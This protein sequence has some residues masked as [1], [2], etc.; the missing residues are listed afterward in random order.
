[1]SGVDEA[2]RIG[3]VAHVAPSPKPDDRLA[4]D[5]VSPWIFHELGLPHRLALLVALV[6]AGISAV[7]ATIVLTGGVVEAPTTYAAVIVANVLG[8]TLAGLMWLRSRPT[9]PYG[10]LLLALAVGSA[11]VSLIGMASPWAH[12]VGVGLG[13]LLAIGITGTA[14]TFPNG[15]LDRGAAAIVGFAVVLFVAV[16]V[17][18]LFVDR[19][20]TPVSPIGRCVPSACPTNPLAMVSDP[21][22]A[23]RLDVVEGIGRAAWGLAALVYLGLVTA[24]ASRPRRRII[25]PVYTTMFLLTSASVV[26]AIVVDTFGHSLP[27]GPWVTAFYSSVRVLF[28]FGFVAAIL[29]A[30]AYAGTALSMMARELGG[31]STVGAVE[32]LV[33]RVLDDSRARLVFWLPRFQHFVDRHGRRVALSAAEERRSW[34][35]FGHGSEKVLGIEHDPALADDDELVEAVG[36]AALMALDNRRL[37]QDLLDSITALRASQRRLVT[38]STAERRR[39]ER[40]L[41]DSTQQKLVA[42]RIQLELAREQAAGHTL[43][44]NRLAALGGELDEAIDE[45]RTFAH[46]IYSPLLADEGLGPALREAAA[47]SGMPV[48]VRVEDVGRLPEAYEEAVYYCCLE[49]LQNAAKHAGRG[50]RVSLDLRREGRMVRFSVADDG[51]GF[52]V[53]RPGAGFGLSSMSDRIGALGG[54]FAVHSVP[55]DGTIV[56]ASL[57]VSS[58]GEE[59][60]ASV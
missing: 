18:Q 33:R 54:T 38:V 60:R 55:G 24:G 30:R 27:S 52:S 53:D 8:F 12:L 36:S 59:R 35:V 2:E 14:I 19:T 31:R 10:R 15:R 56:D 50:A 46:G 44:R 58:A 13:W 1:M 23:H 32:S 39:I 45:L 26:S 4:P 3:S 43:L 25:L 17:P 5:S 22:F 11:L 6:A 16:Q 37:E 48:D 47:R 42:I 57:V 29:L 41:H 7:A 34:H 9:S 40:D 20:L 49:A 51:V 28:P 21:T